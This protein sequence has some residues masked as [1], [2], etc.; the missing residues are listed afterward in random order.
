MSKVWLITGSGLGRALAEAV[1]AA[2][3]N[4]VATA[5]NPAQLADLSERYGGQ[6][7]TLALDVT[8]EAAA[9]ANVEAA[10]KRF[11]RID[12]LVNNA[13]YG[14]V[15]SIEDTSLADFR[16]QIE[17]NLFGTIIMSKAVIALMRGQ[18]AGHII[19]FSSVGGRIGPAGRGAYSAAKI[20][21]EGFSEVLAKEVSPFGVRV[22]VVEPGG[23]RTDFAG[24]ST[25]LAE[26]RAEYAETVGATVRFQ[27]EYDGRQP[28]DPAKAA[29]V[30][31]HIAGL[32]EPPFRLLLGSDAVR[33]VEKADAARIAADREWRAVSVSTDF[34]PDAEVGAMP[35]EKKAG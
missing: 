14:N 20:G 35:W 21:V 2:G 8:N 29:A 24:A 15:G 23:F 25:V 32:G 7:L 10:V 11:G 22:T 12:V 16:A 31:I 3:D 13:G 1:L 19:Q 30:I 9:A 4:L 6:V 33:N 28:G 27:R 5:R 26:G 17:T 18:G 34:E